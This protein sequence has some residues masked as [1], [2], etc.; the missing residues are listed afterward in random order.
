MAKTAGA[1]KTMFKEKTAAYKILNG[2]EKA[3]HITRLLMDAKEFAVKM[4]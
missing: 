2:I 3:M 4:A 1:A